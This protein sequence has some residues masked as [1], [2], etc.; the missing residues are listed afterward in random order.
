MKKK[1]RFLCQKKKVRRSRERGRCNNNNAAHTT[2]QKKISPNVFEKLLEWLG[3]L[4]AHVGKLIDEL[5]SHL[6]RK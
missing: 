3:C 6:K 2:Q 5:L 1:K 4:H